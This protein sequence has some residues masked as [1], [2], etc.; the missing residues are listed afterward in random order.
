[1]ILAA[2]ALLAIGFAAGRTTQGRWPLLWRYLSPSSKPKGNSN[3]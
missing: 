2:L 1:M 3:E